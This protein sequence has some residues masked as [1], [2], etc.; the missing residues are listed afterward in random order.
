MTPEITLPIVGTDYPNKDPKKPTRLFALELC[1]RGD[2]VTLVQ[3]PDNPHD[4]HAIAVYNAEGMMMGYVPAGRAVYVGMQIRRGAE[5]SALFQG[6]AGNRGYIR[7]AFDGDA[8]ELPP[9][10]GSQEPLQDWYA[11]EEFP[12]DFRD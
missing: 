9:A 10:P 7:I 8:P 2:R 5:V 1:Q 6:R 12:E 11:D 3:E 4:E